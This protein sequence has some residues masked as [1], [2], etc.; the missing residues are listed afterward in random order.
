MV[1]NLRLGARGSDVTLNQKALNKA[2]RSTLPKLAEDGIFGPKTQS[3]TIEFQR[4]SGLGADGVIGPNTRAALGTAAGVSGAPPGAPP[5][6]GS[7]ELGADKVTNTVV[8]SLGPAV[9]K[10]KATASLHGVTI[11]GATAIGPPGCLTGPPLAGFMQPSLQLQGDDRAIAQ[12]AIAGISAV[13]ER[14]RASVS[15]P[16][17]PW[18]PLFAA[19]PGPV[20][21]PMPNVPT[22]LASLSA[23]G[24][25]ALLSPSSLEKAMS[26][27]ASHAVRA[28][29][30]PIFSRIS[31]HA[32]PLLGASIAG[33]MVRNVLGQGPVP[34]FAPPV[35]LVG[36][37]V[38]GSVLPNPGIL[39]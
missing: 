17:L 25:G 6:V 13:F 11:M 10:W 26:Q 39:S 1:Q 14:W 22:S 30:A 15:I 9:A 24:L 4:S 31:V 12:A 19:F 7:G 8:S 5:T 38:N 37:V 34:T 36:P 18:Y 23:S 27:A 2:G 3:R 20:A 32:A 21:P 28:K 33:S 29:G 35:I 16:G